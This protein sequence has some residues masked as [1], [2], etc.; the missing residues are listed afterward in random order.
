M[1]SMHIIRLV[2]HVTS[3]MGPQTTSLAKGREAP[4]DMEGSLTALGGLWFPWQQRETQ[5]LS[6]TNKILLENLSERAP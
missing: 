6:A 4:Q 2:P 1:G 3:H 5:C